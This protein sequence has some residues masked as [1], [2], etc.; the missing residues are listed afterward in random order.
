MGSLK[1][2]IYFFYLCVVTSNV[3]VYMLNSLRKLN[4]KCARRGGDYE[5]ISFGPQQSFPLRHNMSATCGIS[6]ET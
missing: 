3:P 2:N 5:I 1:I 6:T 4:D